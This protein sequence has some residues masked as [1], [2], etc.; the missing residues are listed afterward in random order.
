MVERL[1]KTVKSW[2]L[3]KS[4]PGQIFFGEQTLSVSSPEFQEWQRKVAGAILLIFGEYSH[5]LGD[6]NE[7]EFTDLLTALGDKKANR[8]KFWEGVT[9][10]KSM[11]QSMID[12]IKE[13]STTAAM[14]TAVSA[15]P[16][17][18]SMSPIFIGHGRNPV[19]AR[20]SILLEKELGL[21]TVNYESESRAGYSIVPILEKMLDQA[22]FAILVLTAEDETSSGSKRARQNVI[23]EAGLFQGRLGFRKAILLVQDGLEDFSNIA[24]LQHISFEGNQIDQTFHELRRVL[25]REGLIE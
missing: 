16:A 12:E 19:W 13:P 25:K 4:L 5:F 6:F 23:H 11:L 10:A 20:V 18:V 3:L 8:A 9:S 24:G 1:L 17:T 21:E 22:R 2:E 14:S 15:S 7:I